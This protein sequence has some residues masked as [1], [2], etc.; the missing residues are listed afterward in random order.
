[1]LNKN[2]EPICDICNRAELLIYSKRIIYKK[3][4]RKVPEWLCVECLNKQANRQ[5]IP[6]AL[7]EGDDTK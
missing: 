7:P 1:M 6:E 2:D 4:G 3:G 5:A